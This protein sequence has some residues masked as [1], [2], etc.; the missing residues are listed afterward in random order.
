[1][2]PVPALAGALAQAALL[3][4]FAPQAPGVRARPRWVPFATA[5]GVGALALGAASLAT[6]RF[7]GASATEV[8]L[9]SALATGV[10][11]G[12]AMRACGCLPSIDE[13]ALAAWMGVF[14]YGVLA[15]WPAHPTLALA[16]G[17]AGLLPAGLV[18]ASVLRPDLLSHAG[19]TRA[20]LWVAFAAAWLALVSLA[21]G[22]LL[23]ADLPRHGGLVLF[24]L[25]LALAY[26]AAQAVAAL[27]C[28]LRAP[29]ADGRANGGDVA[30]RAVDEHPPYPFLLLGV[31]GLVTGLLVANRLAGLLPEAVA[32]SLVLA[33]VPAPALVR[34]RPRP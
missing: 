30:P 13:T 32:I 34:G 26:A 5:T 7:E 12:I 28:L 2:E 11:L 16:S 17:V 29:R 33:L 14:A 6:G 27:A 9:A 24:V 8:A 20:Y 19:R 18:F 21:T 15:L 25:G 31:L 10:G 23:L 22:E 1:M 4:A 3:S